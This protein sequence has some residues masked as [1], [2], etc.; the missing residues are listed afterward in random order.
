MLGASIG[1]FAVTA[2]LG[3]KIFAEIFKKKEASKSVVFSHGIF[4]ASALVI[5]II[6][7]VK[8]PENFPML[9]LILFVITALLGFVLLALDMSKKTLPK[10]LTIIHA[11][12]AVVSFLLLLIFTFGS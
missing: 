5:L 2:V 1:L 6:Y 3:L 4:A 10:P 7:A 8:N 11:V 9:S 12:T